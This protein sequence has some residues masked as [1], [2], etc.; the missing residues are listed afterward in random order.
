MVNKGRE[1]NEA[2]ESMCQD[3]GYKTPATTIFNYPQ[4]ERMK[5]IAYP[6]FL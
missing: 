5:E 3:Y 1:T 2:I 4:K 6:Q